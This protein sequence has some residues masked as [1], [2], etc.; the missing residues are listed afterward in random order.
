VNYSSSLI[1]GPMT[2]RHVTLPSSVPSGSCID[3]VS[4][5]VT[6]LIIFANLHSGGFAVCNFHCDSAAM[7]I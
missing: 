4:H 3:H 5:A 7:N 2:S 6:L 1:I